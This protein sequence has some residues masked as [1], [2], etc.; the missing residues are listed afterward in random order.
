MGGRNGRFLAQAFAADLLAPQVGAAPG[1]APDS[2]DGEVAAALV[3]GV[4]A[5]ERDE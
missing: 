5:A 4:Y 1:S 3:D 2:V